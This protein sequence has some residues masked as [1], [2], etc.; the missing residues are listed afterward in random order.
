MFDC[1][2]SPVSHYHTDTTFDSTKIPWL[3]ALLG[4]LGGSIQRFTTDPQ[5]FTREDFIE[6]GTTPGV[7]PMDKQLFYSFLPSGGDLCPKLKFL[8]ITSRLSFSD[9]YLQ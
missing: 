5:H 2:D 7:V 8:E 1:L 6:S 4:R 9:E 3:L